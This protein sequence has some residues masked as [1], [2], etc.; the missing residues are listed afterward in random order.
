MIGDIH[1][2]DH[3]VSR[4][5]Q[6]HA[7]EM[8][9]REAK[10]LL[11][12]RS[13]HAVALKQKTVKGDN[14][15]RITDPDVILVGKYVNNGIV[16][17]TILPEPEFSGVSEEDF[18]KIHNHIDGILD[19]R[20]EGIKERSECIN[21]QILNSVLTPSQ[22]FDLEQ[23]RLSIECQLEKLRYAIMQEYITMNKPK[24]ITLGPRK[25]GA[26]ALEIAVR[27]LLKLK[28]DPDIDY[29]LAE[30]QRVCP[31]CFKT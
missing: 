7:P 11:I 27:A 26:K 8:T 21:E 15:W 9:F 12:K 30:M 23:R 18:Y 25:G 5:V 22:R 6:R 1:I 31:E 13:L 19:E 3:A 17:V 28:G 10:S 16:C 14:Q 29:T 20:A 4:F 24:T 2:S